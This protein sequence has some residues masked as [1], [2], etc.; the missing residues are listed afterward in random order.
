MVGEEDGSTKM[1][2]FKPRLS[3]QF[4]AVIPSLFQV[5]AQQAQAEQGE[6]GGLGDHKR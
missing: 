4:Y 1:G 5:Q 2:N 6:G 3:D